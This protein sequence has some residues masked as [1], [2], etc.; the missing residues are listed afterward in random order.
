ME[1]IEEKIPRFESKEQ[2][3]SR[4]CDVIEK[5]E[6]SISESVMYKL[7][8]GA[9]WNFKGTDESY[10]VTLK[11]CENGS[12]R[13]IEICNAENLEEFRVTSTMIENDWKYS[14]KH[15][16]INYYFAIDS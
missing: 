11:W 10:K 4:I 5:G 1:R 6:I 3:F 14:P 8:E 7:E 12:K 2:F 15:P 13:A 9:S 16:T